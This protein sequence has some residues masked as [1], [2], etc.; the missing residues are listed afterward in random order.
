MGIMGFFRDLRIRNK[1]LLAYSTIFIVTIAI[2]SFTIYT[3]VRRSIETSIESELNNTTTALLNM[4]RTSAAISIQ[5]HLRAVAERNREIVA[6]F[7][8]LSRQGRLSSVVAQARARE[9]LL[10]QTIGKTGYI[11]CLNSQGIIDAHPKKALLGVDLSPY[12]FIQNQK[13]RKEGY[14]E[15]DWQN[16]GEETSRPKALYMTYFAPWDWII[17]VSSYREEFNELIKVDDFRESIASAKFGDTGYSYVLDST[18][19]LIVHPKLEGHNYYDARDAGGNFFIQEIINRKNGKIFYNWKNPGEGDSRE[20][21]VIFNYIPEYD[22]IV[23]SS[24]YLEEFY[25][26]LR[27]IRKIVLATVLV[28]LLV[29]LPITMRI[30]ASI[31]NPLISLM[32]RFAK[33]AEGD[34]SVRMIPRSRDEL[35]QLAR[36]FNTFME[37]LDAYSADLQSEIADRKKA[38]AAIRESEAKYR[39][40]VQSANSIILRMDTD[41]N[42]TFFNEYAQRFFGYTEA[43]ILGRNVV[44]TIVPEVDADGHQRKAIGGEFAK[45]PEHFRHHENENVKRTGERVWI[46]WTNRAIRDDNSRIVENLCIGNDVTESRHAQQEM[47]R[48]RRYLQN[49]IDSMPSVLVGTDTGGRITLWNREAEKMAGVSQDAARGRLLAD[50]FPVLASRMDM[51]SE[52]IADRQVRKAEKVPH[53]NSAGARYFDIVVYPLVVVA[54]EG[55]VIR[56]DDVTDRVRMEDMMVQTEKMMSV[57]GLAAGMA[58]EINNPLGGILQSVQNI[59]RRLSPD[60]PDNHR[61]AAGCGTTLPAVQ[62]YLDERRIS[63]FLEGIRDAGARAARIVDNMLN[64]SRRSESKKIPISLTELLENTVELAAHDYD[65]K[66][67]Y[68][69]RRIEIVREFETGMPLVPCTP[70]EI[71]QVILNLLRNAAQAGSDRPRITLR[72]RRIGNAVRFDVADNGVGMDAETRKRVFEPFFTTKDVGIGTGLGLSVSYFIVTNNHNGSMDVVSTPGE[73]SCFS[74]TLPLREDGAAK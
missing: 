41:G 37:R 33:G 14:L 50:L 57:G 12:D 18:G 34:I 49:I 72:L 70:N 62:A 47:T 43:E 11:Y 61:V 35:G 36:Y 27:T 29:V 45:A 20:K 3:F 42:I 7:H 58:H 9:V 15:Y 39:E 40:L 25:A 22:W 23:A 8:A 21:L 53:L 13:L 26:P 16:P 68:D 60:L 66:K 64:F 51:V 44:G 74:V 19:N 54:I 5:N 56:M 1:L 28:S 38:E 67:N 55:A 4:V 65:L 10:S 48:M 31:T 73:G 32:S 2:S 17:S 69:F 6:H 30:S 24:S 63:A 59:H 46:S 71:E 52:V